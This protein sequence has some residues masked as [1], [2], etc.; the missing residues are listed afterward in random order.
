MLYSK[1]YTL[2][3]EL[4]DS[5]S[6]AGFGNG[7]QLLFNCTEEMTIIIEVYALEGAGSFELVV[8]RTKGLG[9]SL[10]ASILLSVTAI[11]TIGYIRTGKRRRKN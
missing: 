5:L 7:L 1:I 10:I 3:W 6:P 11:F 2:D 8:L 4:L 9:F